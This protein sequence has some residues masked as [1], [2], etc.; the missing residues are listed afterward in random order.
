MKIVMQTRGVVARIRTPKL[1]FNQ[2]DLITVCHDEV[3][4]QRLVGLG[5]RDIRVHKLPEGVTSIGRIRDYVETFVIP[6]GE[7]YCG[8]DDN[9]EH[10]WRVDDKFY[11]GLEQISVPEEYRNRD[12]YKSHDLHDES[13]MKVVKE[14]VEKCEEQ[15]TIYGGFAWMENP[16]FRPSKWQRHGYAK[17]KIYVKKNEGLSWQWSPKLQ[18]MFDHAQSFKVIEKYGSVA[19]NRFV[20]VQHPQYEAGGIGSHAERMP[21]REPTTKFLYEHFEGLVGP[22]RGDEDKPAIRLRGQESIDRWRAECG[23]FLVNKL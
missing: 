23:R 7:W 20:Y 10:V 17:A 12:I 4:R 6:R 8:I 14:L 22:T 9:I 15:K 1:F 11:G 19:I 16:G 18:V 3:Q 21:F 5:L 13:L 2:N